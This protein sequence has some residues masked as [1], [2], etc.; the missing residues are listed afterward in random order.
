MLLVALLMA[1]G[2]GA[3]QMGEDEVR[4]GRIERIDPVS[5]DGDHHLGLGMVLGAVAG[6]VLGHQFGGGTGR[7]VLTVMGTLGGGLLGKR[8]Q[9]KY[10]DRRAGQHI[11]V[12]VNNGVAVGI[13]QAGGSR[14]AGRRQGAHRRDRAGRASHP[15][16]MI[17]GWVSHSGDFSDYRTSVAGCGGRTRRAASPA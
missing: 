7:D 16:L 12:K 15:P 5:L 14:A 10:A 17:G 8:V 13:T 6:G 4:F 1:A 9:N 3:Q 11:I 2:A